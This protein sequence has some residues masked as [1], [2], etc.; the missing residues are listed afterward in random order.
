MVDCGHPEFIE[1]GSVDVPTTVESSVARYSCRI[2]YRLRGAST[3]TCLSSG[4]WSG[5]PPVCNGE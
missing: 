5:A 4:V 1:F 2:G 3:R